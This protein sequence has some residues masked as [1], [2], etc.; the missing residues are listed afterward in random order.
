MN[1]DEKN[2][3]TKPSRSGGFSKTRSYIFPSVT[4]IKNRG[5]A[6]FCRFCLFSVI[7]TKVGIQ[8]V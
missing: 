5:S 6:F 2:R 1:T 7:P 8:S 4:S 3:K